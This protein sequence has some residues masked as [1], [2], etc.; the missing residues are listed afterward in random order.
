MKTA[1]IRGI[2]VDCLKTRKDELGYN[3]TIISRRTGISVSALS[4]MFRGTLQWRV[5][6]L[7]LVLSVLRLEIEDVLTDQKSIDHYK[8]EL[9]IESEWH[10]SQTNIAM[11]A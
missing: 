9:I 3:L 8:Q 2:N 5:D 4:A 1:V 11:E 10:A 7:Q 6:K